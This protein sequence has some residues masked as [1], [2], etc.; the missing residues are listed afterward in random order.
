M[1]CSKCLKKFKAGSFGE[2][3]DYSGYN[4]ENW[5]HRNKALHMRHLE[6]IQRSRTLTEQQDIEKRTGVRYSELVRLPYFDIVRHHC[7]DVM[8]NLLLGTAKKM[9]SVWKDCGL[10]HT[11]QLQLIQDNIDRMQVPPQVGRIPSKIYCNTS[12]LTADQWKNWTCIFSLYVLKNILPSDDYDCWVLFSQACI[13]LLQPIITTDDLCQA[14]EKLLNFCKTFE[15]LYGPEKCTPNMHLHCHIRE[16]I[17]DYGPVY[18]TWCFAFERMNGIF[19]SFQKNWIHPEVQLLVKFVNFQNVLT[20]VF[21]FYLPAELRDIFEAQSGKIKDLVVGQGSLLS[22]HIDSLTIHHRNQNI[23]CELTS[24]D[25][26]SEYHQLPAK[27][28][29]QYLPSQ[30]VKWLTEVYKNIYSSDS[31]Y[32]VP[33]LIETFNEVEVLGERFVSVKAKGNSSP[34]IAAFWAGQGGKISE[35]INLLRIGKVMHFFKHS[36][37][38]NSSIDTSDSSESALKRRKVCH[39]FARVQWNSSPIQDANF[40]SPIIN[41]D[42]TFDISGPANFIPLNRVFCRCAVVKDTIKFDYGEDSTLIVIPLKNKIS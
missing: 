31:V 26:T 3:L 17:V 4:R 1:G 25:A 2:K 33:M 8:H 16:T 21:P 15:R 38:I 32:F 18:S 24:I 5:Q 27:R 29:E 28:Y 9:I 36:V 20:T 14:D 22:T 30:D 39:V 6:E 34:Y 7:I 41:V 19:E 13:I 40:P 10:I 11:Q 42:P 37:V 23:T 35:D 12:S